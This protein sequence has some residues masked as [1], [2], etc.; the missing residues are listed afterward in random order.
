MDSICNIENELVKMFSEID[1]EIRII[2]QDELSISKFELDDIISVYSQVNFLKPAILTDMES[3]YDK[4]FSTVTLEIPYALY[5]QLIRHRNVLVKSNLLH[6]L[7][8]SKMFS[9]TQGSMIKVSACADNDMWRS[10]ITK[11]N[12]FVSQLDMWRP[13]VSKLNVIYPEFHLPCDGNKCPFKTD[14]EERIKGTDPGLPCPRF[15][16]LYPEY[17]KTMSITN[18]SK[19][20]QYLVDTNRMNDTWKHEISVLTNS[21]PF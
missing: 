20:E 10:I 16:N 12:C 18:L 6:S 21:I 7:N 19:I 17:I 9:L 2:L 5:A 13:I 14:V 15:I 3:I 4:N 11:R 1:T 8:P